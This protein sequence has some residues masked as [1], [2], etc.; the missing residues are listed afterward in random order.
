MEKGGGGAPAIFPKFPWL[1][2]SL[3]GAAV[4]KVW[5][6]L[7]VKILQVEKI[8]FILPVYTLDHS[9]MG[10]KVSKPVSVSMQEQSGKLNPN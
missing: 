5:Q 1:Y 4:H 7:Q 8:I 10:E 6:S 2:L 3:L 9:H